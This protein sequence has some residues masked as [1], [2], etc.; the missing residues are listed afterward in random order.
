MEMYFSRQYRPLASNPMIVVNEMR[1]EISCHLSAL[2][3]FVHGAL[4]MEEEIVLILSFS[5]KPAS[6]LLLY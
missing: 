1:L 5:V 2:A 6:M 4:I 3:C